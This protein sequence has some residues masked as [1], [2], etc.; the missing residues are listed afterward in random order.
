M[1][2]LESG[3]PTAAIVADKQALRDVTD[4]NLSALTLP[5]LASLSLDEA[6]TEESA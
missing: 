6:L 5:R 1:R 4:I 3:T 2:A